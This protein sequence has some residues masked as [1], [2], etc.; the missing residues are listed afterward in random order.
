LKALIAKKV[1][2]VSMVLF[3]GLIQTTDGISEIC[4]FALGLLMRLHLRILSTRER[5][6]YTRVY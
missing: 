4:V 6:V 5:E 3:S 2:L 1:M